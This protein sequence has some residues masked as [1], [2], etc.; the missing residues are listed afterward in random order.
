MTLNYDVVGTFASGQTGATGS[1]D[2]RSFA[3]WGIVSSDWLGFAGAASGGSG[4]TKAIR[5]DSAYTFADVNSLRRYTTG[6][7]HHQRPVLDPS[8]SHRGRADSLGLQHAPRPDHVSASHAHR[9]GRGSLHRAMC[10]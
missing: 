7:L 5:L 4:A 2:L 8:V 10:W 6:R 9:L 3:P 1:L